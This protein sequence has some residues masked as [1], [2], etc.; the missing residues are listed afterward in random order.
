MRETHSC[1]A[2]KGERVHLVWIGP[3]I[4]E[5]KCT[6]CG[7]SRT[8]AR[9]K[10]KTRRALERARRGGGK[11]PG[12]SEQERAARRALERSSAR[13]ERERG[14]TFGAEVPEPG[15]R[16]VSR[17]QSRSGPGTSAGTELRERRGGRR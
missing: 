11:A 16:S 8:V 12:W 6:G 13:L 3:E 15:A 4:I 14:P 10:V 7:R 1:T 17:R 2:C 9:G 5:R